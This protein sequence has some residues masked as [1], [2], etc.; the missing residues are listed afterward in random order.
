MVLLTGSSLPAQTELFH[1]F[2]ISVDAGVISPRGEINSILNDRPAAG[3][4]FSTSYYKDWSVHGQLQYS[5]LDGSDSPRSVH[6]VKT[7]IGLSFDHSHVFV[8][9]FGVGLANY[10]IRTAEKKSREGFLMDDNESEI[11][12]YPF[13]S[14]DVFI[15]ERFFVQAGMEWNMILSEPD[16]THLPV[17]RLGAGWCWR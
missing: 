8:P 15:F 12:I 13:L 17:V 7:G 16:Q 10:F 6:Y 9:A 1:Q 11:G 4:H 3:L 2:Q 5:L 14:W